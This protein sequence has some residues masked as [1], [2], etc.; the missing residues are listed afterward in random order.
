MKSKTLTRVLQCPTLG[1]LAEVAYTVTNG[2]YNIQ[3]CP[4]R[5]DTGGCDRQCTKMLTIARNSAEWYS[6]Y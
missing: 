6:R 5:N 1:R 3:S 2:H 4:A